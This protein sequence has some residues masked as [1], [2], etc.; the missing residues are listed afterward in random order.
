MQKRDVIVVILLSIITCGIYSIYWFYVTAESL[1]RED[2]NGEPLMNYILA[3]LLS[4]V[5]CG[6]FGIYWEYKFFKK[7]DVVTRQDNWIVSLLLSIFF[8]PIVGMA[9][10]QSAINNMTNNNISE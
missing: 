7:S 6:I 8:T 9:I 5:T 3:I 4:I 2:S 10:T 1:N